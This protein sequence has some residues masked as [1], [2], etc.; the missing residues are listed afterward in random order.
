MNGPVL[1][2]GS[3]EPRDLLHNAAAVLSLLAALAPGAADDFG[4]DAADGLGL[5]LR[6]VELTIEAAVARL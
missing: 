1:A 4:H 3:E 2:F 6:A 5:V